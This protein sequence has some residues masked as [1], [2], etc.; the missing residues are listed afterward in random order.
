MTSENAKP[1]SVPKRHHFV[2]EMVLRRFTLDGENL[3]LFSKLDR[4]PAI[5][6]SK[7]ANAFVVGHGYSKVD[8]DG[9]KTVELEERFS[10]KEGVWSPA[11]DACITAAQTGDMS[12]VQNYRDTVVEFFYYQWIRTPGFN[13]NLEGYKEFEAMLETRVKEWVD[14]YR[15]LTETEQGALVG[16]EAAER[17]RQNTIVDAMGSPMGSELA[18]VLSECRFDLVILTDNQK[19]FIIGSQPVTT[20][21]RPGSPFLLTK[22]GADLWLPVASRAALKVVPHSRGLGVDSATDREVQAVNDALATECDT[23][24][25]E[26]REVLEDVLGR[27]GSPERNSTATLHTP[28]RA[29]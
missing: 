16:L 13:Q 11:L 26:S 22:P 20:V 10:Q 4:K 18:K 28:T 29:R 1:R 21:N 7:I 15:P 27:Q 19:P 3:Q 12:A 6:S 24:G 14:A 23:I 5:R 8:R 17:M 9:A 25:A 2:P